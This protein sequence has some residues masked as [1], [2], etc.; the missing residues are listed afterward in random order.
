MS[1]R[2]KWERILESEGLGEISLFDNT[3]KNRN[4]RFIST[5]AIDESRA[6][7]ESTNTDKV[8]F[9]NTKIHGEPTAIGDMD[10]ARYYRKLS[11]DVESLPPGWDRDELA[12][13]RLWADIGVINE[14]ARVLQ[15]DGRRA[16]EI[17]KKFRE[18]V[19]NAN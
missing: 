15:I 3:G 9:F 6:L 14:A 10:V 13:L 19:A 17:V 16:K 5:T 7:D 2:D 18:W 12:F 4:V 8:E 1:E 11:I